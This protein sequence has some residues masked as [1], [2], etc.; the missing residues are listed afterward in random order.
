MANILLLD[1]NE[2]A[3][4]AMQGILTRAQHRCLIAHDTATA[5]K[6]L[7]ELV[8]LDLVILELKLTK[9]ENGMHFLQH[10][11]EDCF[12]KLIPVVVYSS[13]THQE[14]VKKALTLKIQNYLIKPY[15][16]EAIYA[17]IEKATANPWR[18][19]HFEEEKSFCTQMGMKPGELKKMLHELRVALHAAVEPLQDCSETRNQKAALER[20][21]PLSER[22]EAAG[23]WGVVEYLQNLKEKLDMRS[24]PALAQSKDDL[25]FICLLI[26]CHIDHNYTP[27]GFYSEQER[28]EQE[29]AKLRAYWMEADLSRGPLVHPS[30]IE[31]HL[32]QLQAGPV[33]DTVAAGFLMNADGRAPSLNQL[34]DLVSKDPWLTA[35]VLITANHLDHDDMTSIEDIRLAVTMIG[36]EKL[37]A[38]AKTMPLVE[39]RHFRMLPV[40]WAHYW[41]L[42]VAV[43]RVAQYAATNL[44]LTDL[45]PNAY[46]AGLLHDYG[47][48][49]LVQQHPFSFQAIATYA[50]Q[51]SIPLH[52][53]EK[54]YLGWTTREIGDLLARRLGL[55]SMYCNVIRYVGTP[56]EL[57]GNNYMVA[58]I[59]LAR[60]LCMQNQIGFS[61]EPPLPLG[62]L[63]ETQSWQ[64]LRYRVF[65]SF[66]LKKFES[67]THNFCATLK[68]ELS[69][70]IT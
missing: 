34:I 8:K 26:D 53:A 23:A 59:T 35:Q 22:A 38:M 25:A 47:R 37:T 6:M 70:H 62:P 24:W 7:R 49:P 15:R 67:Q 64:I 4:R 46:A 20:I 51:H 5:F 43:A 69:G 61:G 19:L 36:Y 39:E 65:P 68:Q 12:L 63:E 32:D 29:E 31:R 16:D 48:L 27:T 50:K 60:N 11:R 21:E 14:I 54:K 66:N 52:E 28:K 45:A 2:I 9:G 10:L 55:P 3:C 58:L 17:E 41:M 18:M 42:Q 44:E 30:E 33:I 57:S 13:V 40:T 56:E 1:D